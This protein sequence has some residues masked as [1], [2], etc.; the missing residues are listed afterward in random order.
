[1]APP[2][3]SS[4]RT[5]SC[6][7]TIPAANAV[8]T[9][10]TTVYA[11]GYVE[12]TMSEPVTVSDSPVL[13]LTIGASS[14][15]AVPYGYVDAVVVD[16]GGSGYTTAS[17]AF[18]TAPGH[19]G[20]GA[21]ATVHI[22]G[23]AIVR[24]EIT[25]PGEGY[26]ELPAV[27]ITGD[28]IG[29]SATASVLSLTAG[30][31]VVD[32]TTSLGYNV[33][34][35]KKGIRF[36]HEGMAVSAPGLLPVGT[37]VTAIALSTLV[38]PP[39]YTGILVQVSASA[40]ASGNGALNTGPKATFVVNNASASTIPFGALAAGGV[41]LNQANGSLLNADL[42]AADPVN[43]LLVPV[44]SD[45]GT[46]YDIIQLT[47][48]HADGTP[49]TGLTLTAGDIMIIRIFFNQQVYFPG[50]ANAKVYF[51]YLDGSAAR[52]DFAINNHGNKS[53]ALDF[54]WNVPNGQ[55]VDLCSV[56]GLYFSFQG[57][58]DP[59]DPCARIVDLPHKV[60]PGWE[61][62]VAMDIVSSACTEAVSVLET[63]TVVGVESV[64]NCGGLFA[65]DLTF[66]SVVYL[67]G[68]ASLTVSYT[69]LTT[70]GEL[71]PGVAVYVSGSGTATLTFQGQAPASA[72]CAIDLCSLQVLS[73]NVDPAG[74]LHSQTATG[75]AADV[76]AWVQQTSIA[77]P[78]QTTVQSVTVAT[79]SGG[80][81]LAYGEWVDIVFTFSNAVG[82][83][84]ASLSL[85]D[86]GAGYAA[87][88]AVAIVAADATG[89]G[90]TASCTIAGGA[91][92]ALTL[93]SG[94][95]VYTATP[96]V[97]FTGASTTPASAT[98]SLSPQP[99][100][101]IRARLDLTETIYYTIST[102]PEVFWDAPNVV[103]FRA[104]NL[105][106]TCSLHM[107]TL[108]LTNL[109][110]LSD[111]CQQPPYASSPY[112]YT[113]PQADCDLVRPEALYM[114]PFLENGGARLCV[115]VAYD[116]GVTALAAPPV[117]S[118]TVCYNRRLYTL[119]Y[120]SQASATELQF[121]VSSESLP[122]G[123]E[124]CIV[125]ATNPCQVVGAS[126]GLA[127]LPGQVPLANA[128]AAIG[129]DPYV[130]GADGRMSH[131]RGVGPHA[132]APGVSCT[133]K[134]LGARDADRLPAALWRAM[135][136]GQRAHLLAGGMRYNGDMEFL[137]RVQVGGASVDADT[138]R[139]SDGRHALSLPG[140]TLVSDVD[141]RYMLA[142]SPYA[143]QRFSS[144][145]RL[146]VSA[147]VFLLLARSDNP[148]VRSFAGVLTTEA[149]AR[150]MSGSRAGERAVARGE[151]F[152]P[153]C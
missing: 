33:I 65:L 130:V 11:R 99:T 105:V 7:S 62:T 24:I 124:I 125:S 5:Y 56:G 90:A 134:T 109:A 54:E 61:G 28:G 22:V 108:E 27:V 2:F 120:E 9:P 147:G 42:Q 131:L 47:S 114:T 129:M 6:S 139:L 112:S 60:G 97:T 126:S 20:V 36:L 100:L 143:R 80:N 103:R 144:V 118:I 16:S 74:A 153:V 83:Q 87:A 68:G 40:I 64:V 70:T 3:V 117:C 86:G 75:P 38:G 81:W 119:P 44:F 49:V 96:A 78:T 142:G 141:L 21:E 122:K 145:M 102:A 88:P 58:D 17:V 26:Q 29:A 48:H 71:R 101:Q 82:L 43:P 150:R 34:C 152:V 149:G 13:D 30:D 111:P 136:A 45:D 85:L 127:W 138:W 55:T 123:G 14:Y 146:P 50:S 72:P 84:V 113:P 91:V 93:V 57:G 137:D 115:K 35:V 53:V 63:I 121:A 140:A 67:D 98:A 23:G 76:S 107:C 41:V 110:G 94:G 15:T 51:N 46:T 31:G 92:D 106:Q 59:R 89:F 135:T 95:A 37:T 132:M 10:G 39:N 128:C 151:L 32:F 66:D 52:N 19:T 1:M 4:I 18:V 104:Y 77:T 73:V 116:V 12:L 25:N 148:Q 79:Q 133:L 8:V 69:V